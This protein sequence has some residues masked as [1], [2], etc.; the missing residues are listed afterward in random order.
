MKIYTSHH[1]PFP[2]QEESIFTFLCQRH[3]DK[4]PRD[5]TAYIDA[6]SGKRISRGQFRDLCMELG[7]GL[8]S[9]FH[10]QGGISL[11]RGDTV[12][13]FSSNS[14]SWPI[15]MFSCFAAGLKPTL[16]N[17][18]Y[19]PREVEHQWNDSTAK[20]VLVHPNLLSVALE[21]FK[22]LGFNESEAKRRIIIADP[23]WSL[24]DT[25]TGDYVHLG[26]IIGKGKL[27]EEE[28]FVGNQSY[29]TTVLCYSS[30][31]TGKPK[32]VETTHC[33]LTSQI[34]MIDASFLP[35]IPQDCILG[36]LPFYHVYGA[37]N[38]LMYPFFA[39]I[40]VC[41][42]VK[43]DVNE[44][45]K[46]IQKYSI[47]ILLGVPPIFLNLAKSDATE[48]YSMKSLRLLSSGAAPLGRPLMEELRSRLAKLGSNPWISQG[49]GSTETSPA[50]HIMN[51]ED[52]F[53]KFGSVGRLLPNLEARLVVDGEN[54][55]DADDGKPGELWI[56]G[57]TV[58]KGYLNNPT[59]TKNTVT[60]DGWYK[61]GDVAV[62]DGEGYYY[63]VD[64]VKE[65]IK[66]KGFQVPPAELESILLQHP[67]I[68]DCAVVGIYSEKQVTE[69]PR[70][71][72]VHKNTNTQGLLSPLDTR[73][74]AKSIQKWV[75]SRVARHKYL[76]GG[77]SVIDTI[78]KSAAGKILRRELR[79]LAKKEPLDADV[80]ARL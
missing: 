4:H 58:M 72:I 80:L 11:N 28:K 43:W 73:E 2:I 35:V 44:S 74:F 51:Y 17:S 16:A 27:Q 24:P 77:V 42:Q 34:Q 13:I 30:G 55:I 46:M 15:I 3:F 40:P 71:Y 10:N 8:R 61:T 47:T 45:C 31:T 33:N 26:D 49:Y 64:R 7:W 1:P 39:G 68:A 20:V 19:T 25:T 41:I 76:R 57:P 79:E 65:L 12:M 67:D 9:E 66:Y 21:M 78:P 52:C 48:K 6:V 32:G 18:A 75:Q 29:E 36:V 14:L 38:L 50:S 23:D 62:R 60:S 37:I 5:K 56:R 70:A 54:S 59:A 63:I 53:R 69:L 22:G